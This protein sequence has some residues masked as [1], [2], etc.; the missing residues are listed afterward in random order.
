MIASPSPLSTQSFRRASARSRIYMMVR[1]SRVKDPLWAFDIG[2]G[3]LQVKSSALLFPGTYMDLQ[4]RLPASKEVLKVGAQVATLGEAPDDDVL[5]GGSTGGRVALGL[6]FC[7]LT[8]RAQLS[9]YRF[10][11]K[12][13]HLWT[14]TG[15]ETAQADGD[16]P[17]AELL[18][19]AYSALQAEE[20][21]ELGFVCTPWPKALKATVA[22]LP[23][24]HEAKPIVLQ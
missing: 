21:R 6:R 23:K 9:I 13:R 10:L 3:G 24:P 8:A 12:R 22:M 19:D 7:K 5:Q 2:L 17:F 15:D 20:L 4:F 1:A 18:S 11:D 14:T 16:T